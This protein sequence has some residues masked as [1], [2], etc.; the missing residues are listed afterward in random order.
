MK[1]LKGHDF[2]SVS[3]STMKKN[4]PEDHVRETIIKDPINIYHIS[5]N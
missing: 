3:L 5:E 1:K 2:F 4:S